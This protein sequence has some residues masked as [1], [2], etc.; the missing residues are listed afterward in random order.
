TSSTPPR[1]RPRRPAVV[2]GRP[3]AADRAAARPAPRRRP[4]L[5]RRSSRCSRVR[6]VR[7]R[8]RPPAAPVTARRHRGAARAASALAVAAALLA[9]LAPSAAAHGFTSTVYADATTPE[10]GVVRTELGLE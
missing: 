10:P 4:A 2:G 9:A 8:P 7:Y 5:A 3:E 6:R 1:S